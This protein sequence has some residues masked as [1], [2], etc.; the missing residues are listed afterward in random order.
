MKKILVVIG[1][2]MS[3]G[4][5][6]FLFILWIA[7][8]GKWLGVVGTIL[9]IIFPPGLVIFPIV[10]WIVEGVFPLTYFAILGF[11]IFGGIIIGAFSED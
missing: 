4:S 6:L 3:L 2:I 7:T 9:A 8:M 10:F 1:K 11:G 5:F